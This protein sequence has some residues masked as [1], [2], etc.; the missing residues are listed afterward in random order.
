MWI[1]KK[2]ILGLILV[3]FLS[4]CA[5]KKIVSTTDM[6]EKEVSKK[7]KKN[8]LEGI[9]E[10]TLLF[11]TFST[12]AKTK[13]SLDNKS[14]NATLNIRIKHNEVIWISAN[15][16]LGI[17]AARIMITP[18]RIQIINRLQSTYIDKPF[19]YIYNFTSK[20]LSFSELE[21]LFVGNSLNF[22]ENPLNT[23]FSIGSDY[24]IL[25]NLE[26]LVYEMSMGIDYSLKETK[27]SE[28]NKEQTLQFSYQ[29]YGQVDDQ[30]IPNEV[31]INL[32]AAKM[33]LAAE[34]KFE[35]ISLNQDLSFPF[36]VPERYKKI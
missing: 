15:A 12:K 19:D 10:N 3:L 4:A 30:T 2:K 8:L 5:S 22:Y 26:D 16:F 31:N 13:L 20:E 1:R 6:S 33:N 9:S 24:K 27:L 29:N 32:K 35:D 23:I 36:A 34:M 11:E 7:E 21:D 28:A 25:G 17:E 18:D 14:F